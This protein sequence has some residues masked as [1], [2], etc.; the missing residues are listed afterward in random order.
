M[1]QRVELISYDNEVNKQ[2]LE[3]VMGDFPLDEA[4]IT[5]AL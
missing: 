1:F 2:D 5:N 3:A 4:I